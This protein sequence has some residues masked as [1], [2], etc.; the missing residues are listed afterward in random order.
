LESGD[1]EAAVALMSNHAPEDFPPHWDPLPRFSDLPYAPLAREVLWTMQRLPHSAAWL[2]A[3]YL[4]KFRLE[5]H[6][7]TYG[8]LWARLED[9]EETDHLLELLETLPEGPPLVRTHSEALRQYADPKGRPLSAERRQRL[10]NLL[11]SA[12][13]NGS[14]ESGGALQAVP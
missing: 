1:L 2:R 9:S 14:V 10:R 4:D 3:I 13:A 11:E 5:L 12:D 8:P 7:L 6:G